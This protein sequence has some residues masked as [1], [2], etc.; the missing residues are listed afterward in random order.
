M[1]S[2]AAHLFRVLPL[3]TALLALPGVNKAVHV[4]YRLTPAAQKVIGLPEGVV[5]GQVGSSQSADGPAAA[6][7]VSTAE[8]IR[9]CL[10][11]AAGIVAI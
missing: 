7:T 3:L 5:L 8:L 6:E 2:Q 4:P 9:Q 1:Q 11:R 10:D